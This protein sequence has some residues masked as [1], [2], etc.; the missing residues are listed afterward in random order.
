MFSLKW[1]FGNHEAIIIT[2][3]ELLCYIITN[4]LRTSNSLLAH[5]I[6]MLPQIQ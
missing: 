1:I 2:S 3:D 6:T 4:S 5:I